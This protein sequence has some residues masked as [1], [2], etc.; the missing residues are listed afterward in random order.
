MNG[1]SFNDFEFP[2]NYEK[3]D[4][5]NKKIPVNFDDKIT[6]HIEYAKLYL[7]KDT[8]NFNAFDETCDASVVLCLLRKAGSLPAALQK[9]ANLVQK[10]R[11][12]WAHYKPSEWVDDNFKQRF[13][14]MKQLVEEVGLSPSDK[15]KLLE[16][17]NACE[18]NG[19]LIFTRFYHINNYIFV[20][21]HI[22]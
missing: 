11:N 9:A 21:Q 15:S 14:D 8:M 2:M 5:N 22:N 19:N 20:K 16:D 3:D 12:I 18:R 17:L 6:S 13:N 10:G 1:H 4:A 7:E